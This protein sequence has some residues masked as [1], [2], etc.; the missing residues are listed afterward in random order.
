MDFCV[1][2]QEVDENEDKNKKVLKRGFTVPE[3]VV[4]N[5]E[6]E[7]QEELKEDSSG[8]Q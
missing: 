2:G 1:C 4:S 3:I 7:N 8:K 5:F 6:E